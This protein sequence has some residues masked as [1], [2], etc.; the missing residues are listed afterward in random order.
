LHNSTLILKQT[1]QENNKKKDED[2]MSK[3]ILNKKNKKQLITKPVLYATTIILITLCFAPLAQSCKPQPGIHLIKTGPIYAYAG[4]PI[5]Y[6]YKVSNTENMPLSDVTV[7]D[8]SCG[9]VTYVSGDKNKNEKLD[10]SETWTFS[11]TYTPTFTFPDLLTNS[12]TA[13]GTWG[14]QTAEDTDHYTLYPFILRK[15]VL[16]YWEGE[17]IDYIDPDTQF[18]VTMTRCQKTLDTFS[19]SESTPKNI[20]LSQGTYKF[21]EVNVP[22]GYI[23]AYEQITFTTGETYPDFSALNII[24]FDLSVQKTGPET[25]YPN[26]QITYH[27]TVSNNGPASVTPLLSDDHSQPVYTGG[28]SDSDGLID[29]SETWTYD[30]TTTINSEPGSII[31][32]TVTVTD[33]EGAN[34]AADH[35][36]LGGDRNLNNNIAN[37]SV[38]V[39]PQ[40]QEP[41]DN[42]TQTPPDTNETEPTDT[43]ETGE[44][45]DTNETQNPE[46][47]VEPIQPIVTTTHTHIPHSSNIAPI[48]NASGP[49]NAPIDEEI[50]FNGSR[51]YDPDGTIIYY[52]WSFGD[53]TTATGE[54]ATHTYAHAGIYQVLLTVNDNLGVSDTDITNATIVTPN[55]P[56][57]NPLVAGPGNG[58][59]NTDY[60]YAFVSID[61]DNDDITYTINWGDG[62]VFTSEFLPNGQYFSMIHRWDTKGDYTITV[63]ASDGKLSTASTLVVSIHE[64]P[65]ADYI[66]LFALGFLALIALIAILLYSKTKKKN[67]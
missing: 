19:I 64:T 30:A 7:T 8:D 23:S 41:Q 33:A 43:N 55:R 4:E 58:T 36:W 59:T 53:G 50:Q 37:W 49:Y 31:I 61:A 67:K 21:T 22:Q 47:P 14:D 54:K 63:T 62:S 13:I 15:N 34:R 56:P 40:P 1:K 35:W 51:S 48:A 5:T 65:I 27:F 57:T 25:C 66:A 28:D 18:T 10:Q 11:C 42:D 26:E 3:K 9:P 12:A 17:N 60:S 45:Q 29:P 2:T 39:I 38:T 52:G 24:T 6:T 32:N 20:W 16:L 44:P 46:P